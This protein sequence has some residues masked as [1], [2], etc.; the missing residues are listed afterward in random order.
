MMAG[1]EGKRGEKWR[2]GTGLNEGLSYRSIAAFIIHWI[3]MDSMQCK[4]RFSMPFFPLF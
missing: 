1:M 3:A 2:F 4:A